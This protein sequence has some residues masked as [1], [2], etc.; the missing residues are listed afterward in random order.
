MTNPP[1]SP[2]PF[3][4]LAADD[5]TSDAS[6]TSD[7]DDDALLGGRPKGTTM[8]NAPD[9]ANNIEEATKEAV[10][11]FGKM[12]SGAEKKEDCQKAHLRISSRPACKKRT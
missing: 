11:K 4:V 1:S 12:K 6:V 3:L 10:T 7:D 9:R 5:V 2:R 8:A